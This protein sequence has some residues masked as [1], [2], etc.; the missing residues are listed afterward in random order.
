MSVSPNSRDRRLWLTGDICNLHQSALFGQKL[1][2]DCYGGFVYATSLYR[3][4]MT[5]F[6]VKMR[7]CVNIDLPLK[8]NQK[9]LGCCLDS[10]AEYMKS[11]LIYAL[12]LRWWVSFSSYS[13]H[14]SPAK[15]LQAD[16][17][18]VCMLSI[19]VWYACRPPDVAPIGWVNR[20]IYMPK[21]RIGPN[22][23]M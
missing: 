9:M 1:Q 3:P 4:G 21:P 10:S 23:I 17:A 8:W 18:M 20:D 2:L 12:P 11:R 6:C 5:Q 13:I 15:S 22:Y 7:R 16:I 19:C 14:V